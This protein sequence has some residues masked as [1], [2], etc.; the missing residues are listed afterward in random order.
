MAFH[1][2]KVF[3]KKGQGHSPT[4][5]RMV[6]MTIDAPELDWGSIDSDVSV[7]DFDL[8]ETNSVVDLLISLLSGECRA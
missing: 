3:S 5:A 6:I 8:A 4:K 1:E 7:L 2:K